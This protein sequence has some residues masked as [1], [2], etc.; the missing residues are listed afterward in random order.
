MI[1]RLKRPARSRAVLLAAC[2]LFGCGKNPPHA[3]AP[4]A[5]A[6]PSAPGPDDGPLKV[7]FV[8]VGPVGDGGWTYAHDQARKSVE[9]E[10]G[11]RVETRYV[12]NVAEGAAAERTFRELARQGHRLIFGTTFGY[13]EAMH[14]VAKDF[15]DVK[16]EHATGDRTAPNVAVYEARTYEGAYLAGILAGKVSKSKRLGFVASVPIPEVVRNINAYTLGARSVDPDITTR[17]A[18]VGKWFDPDRERA[19]A[20]ELI[21]AGADVLIQ[22]TDSS[23][24]LKTA[25]EKG[26]MAF[27]W[28]SDMN[29]F[30]Q[31]AHLGSAA[32]DWAPYYKKVVRDVLD[33][34]W[35]PGAVW[36]GVRQNAVKLASPNPQLPQ[37]V[38]LFLGERI[39]AMRAGGLRPFQGT[40][41][42]QGGNE[43]VAAGR[44]L[45][46]DELKTM[47]FL[48]QGVIGA[49]PE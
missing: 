35:K 38:L 19:C 33:E 11:D 48:V 9:A 21:A 44:A 40:L 31:K 25:Q 13:M 47:R 30:A 37:E 41:F 36:W 26:V 3:A 17:V 32:I 49:L 23:A 8:Y 29:T 27:G 12:E 34:T 45:R 20:L 39:A 16:F 7:A 5:S 1:D 43:V 46:D 18:W 15:P 10:F 28:D 2:M 22:N 14:A 6:T 24:V 42:D 4:A